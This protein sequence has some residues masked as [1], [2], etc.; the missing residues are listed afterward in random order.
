[1]QDL[2]I[3][4]NIFQNF[5]HTLPRDGMNLA[6]T[7]KAAL[8]LFGQLMTKHFLGRCNFQSSLLSDLDML[9]WFR[10]RGIVSYVDV[11]MGAVEVGKYERAR[12]VVRLVD[13]EEVC[14]QPHFYTL[15]S[16]FAVCLLREVPKDLLRTLL[17]KMLHYKTLREVTSLFPGA[18][19]LFRFRQEE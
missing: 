12:E 10:D 16:A 18:W 6:L 8:S 11:M 2:H 9:R 13:A 3:L 15:E 17:L 7:C 1:M 5:H 4:R 19:S 14:C